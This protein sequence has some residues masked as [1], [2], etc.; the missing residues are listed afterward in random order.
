MAVYPQ[1]SGETDLQ[2]ALFVLCLSLPDTKMAITGMQTDLGLQQLTVLCEG[3]RTAFLAPVEEYFVG[4]CGTLSFVCLI[5][6]LVLFVCSFVRSF[7]CSFMGLRVSS[8]VCTFVRFFARSFV[9]SLVCCF[10]CILC[11]SIS[12][13]VYW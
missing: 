10:L 2:S 12:F 11:G 4:A 8:F 6:V 9:G 3:V 1:E 5:C 7:V 13:G